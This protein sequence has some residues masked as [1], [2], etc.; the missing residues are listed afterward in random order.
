VN[1]VPRRSTAILARLMVCALA[2][3]LVT[4]LKAPVAHGTNIAQTRALIQKISNQLA[5]EELRSESLSQQ[6][7]KVQSQLVSLT[8]SI[9]Q[10]RVQAHSTQLSV[11]EATKQLNRALIRY[12]VD[13]SSAAN[14]IALFDQNVTKSDA[15]LVYE[16]QVTGN[17]QK[18]Q[19]HLTAQEKSL[20]LTVFYQSRERLAKAQ[21]ATQTKV[22]LA[23]NNATVIST[24]HTLSQVSKELASKIIGY[25]IYVAIIAA[26]HN[27]T[28]GVN[29]AVVAATAVGG[30]AAGN[31]VIAAAEAVHRHKTVTGTSAGTKAGWAAVN[32]ARSQIGVPYVWGGESPGHG[33]DCS[34][35]TQWAWA[36]AGFS[37]PRVT[38]EQWP[39]MRHIPLTQLQPG[40]LLFY[41]NLDND[42]SIDH[43]VMYVGS[44]PFGTNTVIA[45]AHT[46]TNIGYEPLFTYG[47]YGAARP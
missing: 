26:R 43:V 22:L 35:L 38:S 14:S 40:D 42:F 41:Y 39:A 18:L 27:D 25:E 21:A 31:L 4:V 36:K 24:Q 7:D 20:D 44:G 28:T 9:A 23:E 45:A 5:H 12:Y 33:F 19:A 16:Q 2:V 3:S 32:A 30:Q 1:L 37:I 47:L 6:Y 11:K 17:L 13:G 15:R 34:G 8:N 10:L 29:N 46:G